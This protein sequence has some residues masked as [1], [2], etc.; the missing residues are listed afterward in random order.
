[1][2][3]E[4]SS[5]VFTDGYSTSGNALQY[6][7]AYDSLLFSTLDMDISTGN[8]AEEFA[9]FMVGNGQQSFLGPLD[10]SAPDTVAFVAQNSLA[11]YL[12]DQKQVSSDQPWMNNNFFIPEDYASSPQTDYLL[13]NTFSAT[14]TLL[15]MSPSIWIPEWNQDHLSQ[16]Y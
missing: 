16:L 15:D 14:S 3:I 9:E 10:T 5:A 8:Y 11:L 1:M 13:E 4:E 6:T 2:K 7:P 12:N